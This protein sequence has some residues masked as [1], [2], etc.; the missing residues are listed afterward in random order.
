MALQINSS[1]VISNV[2]F[3]QN[4]GEVAVNVQEHCDV[5]ITGCL[6][7]RNAGAI[8]T[9]AD[10]TINIYHSQFIQNE[11]QI[12]DTG[13]AI[14]GQSVN[15]SIHNSTFEGHTSRLVGGALL[16]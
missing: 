1:A 3:Y 13:G 10:C 11:A 16:F 12:D 8:F 4:G 9:L 5:R 6:F 2:I 14:T 7:E 15:V